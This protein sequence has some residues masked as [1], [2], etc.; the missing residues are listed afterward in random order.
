MKTNFKAHNELTKLDAAIVAHAKADLTKIS[1][2][3]CLHSAMYFF[4]DGTGVD[5]E[6][7]KTFTH[8]CLRNRIDPERAAKGIWNQL[9][10]EQKNRVLYLLE[11]AGYKKIQKV[12]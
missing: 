12:D 4:F 7:P 2:R 8:L 10:I 1:D 5:E 11:E 3:N 9:T 6:R